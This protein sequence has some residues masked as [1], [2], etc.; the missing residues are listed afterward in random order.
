[1]YLLQNL[2]LRLVRIFGEGH[3]ENKKYKDKILKLQKEYKIQNLRKLLIFIN[4]KDL[5]KDMK[6]ML[7]HVVD[8]L[9]KINK[10]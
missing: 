5:I 9:K 6:K 10:L 4:L 7:K 1:M 2:L 3:L 8:F